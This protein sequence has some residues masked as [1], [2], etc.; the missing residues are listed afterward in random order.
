MVPAKDQR[1]Y[2]R[3]SS[4]PTDV[5]SWQSGATP[6]TTTPPTT[7]PPSKT[8]PDTPGSEPATERSGGGCSA[9]WGLLGSLGLAALVLPG[10][11]RRRAR[12]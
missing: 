11:R 1:G 10:V 7:T 8:P 3:P 2:F 5:G 6:P 12:R 9:G 4:G